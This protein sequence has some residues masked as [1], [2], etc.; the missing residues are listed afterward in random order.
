MIQKYK[1]K[2]QFIVVVQAKTEANLT[3]EKDFWEKE[4]IPIWNDISGKF[5]RKLGVISSPQAVILDN[6]H[7]IIYRGNYFNARYDIKNKKNLAEA[8]LI[9]AMEKN[10]Q[11]SEQKTRQAIGCV[12]P[13]YEEKM[14]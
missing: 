4:N 7:K 8:A 5:A 13:S 10:F 14:E 3:K 12:L 11:I 6:S 1:E 2:I 9:E